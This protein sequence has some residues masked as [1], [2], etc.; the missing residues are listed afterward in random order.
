[1]SAVTAA[2]PACLHPRYGQE[3][4]K[5][6]LAMAVN[7]LSRELTQEVQST[8]RE[9]R[10]SSVPQNCSR[11]PAPWVGPQKGCSEGVDGS[12]M[13]WSR[14]AVR[15]AQFHNLVERLGVRLGSLLSSPFEM[16]LMFLT[17]QSKTH[18]LNSSLWDLVLDAPHP[19]SVPG[20][21]LTPWQSAGS[22]S[23]AHVSSSESGQSVS[24]G[25]EKQVTKIL[26]HCFN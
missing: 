6:P 24:L 4:W 1:M 10:F 5:W 19:F 14:S 11:K 2:P 23:L 3:R 20:S 26:Q 21:L 12:K 16:L 22:T 25:S 17:L 13:P 9:L 8:E 18:S 15:S 7:Y